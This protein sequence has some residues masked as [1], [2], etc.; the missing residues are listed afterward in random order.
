MLLPQPAVSA[1]QP[2]PS[3]VRHGVLGLTLALTAVAFLDR[4]CIATAAPAMK[5]DLQLSDAQMGYVFSAFT[6]AYALFEVPSGWL[7][8]RFGPRLMLTRIVVWW[9]AMTAATGAVGGFVSLVAVR[10][11]F[12][13]GEAGTFPSMAR[14]YARWLPAPERGRAFGLALMTAAL[15]GAVTQPLVVAMLDLMHWRYTFPIFGLVGVVWA[16]AWF[17]WFRDDPH[18]HPGVNTTELHLIGAAP[19]VPHHAVPWREM[20]RDRSMLAL[21]TMYF[22]VIYGWYFYIT[23]LPTYLLRA[24]GFDLVRVGWL[25]ALPLVSI[26]V[27]V[28]VG[29][30][31]SDVLARH[32]GLR[33]GRGT[34]GLIG[35][36]LAAVAIV[37]ALY[38]ETPLTAAL[39]L[40]SAAGLAALGVSPAWAV[41]LEIGGRHA[42]VVSGGM[43]T[44][45]NLGGTLS[46]LVVGLCLQMWDSWTVPLITVAAGYLVAALCWLSIDPAA[47]IANT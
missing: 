22:G 37:A 19:P 39:L 43:N 27:G 9:S 42:G 47:P 40:A 36:P 31:L 8:D 6:L 15:G 41:C 14:A 30:W 38:S 16:L 13:M 23:W 3:H 5:A 11:L 7:A 26:A 20:R 44:F 2:S 21:C 18:H 12:G 35:L 28:L 34:P 25:S 29:G 1:I 4:V 45:G 10:F 46:S 33:A 32:W 17:R 24:R